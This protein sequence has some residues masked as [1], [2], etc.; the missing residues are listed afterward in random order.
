[1][2]SL[3]LQNRRYLVFKE[4]RIYN[5]T[6]SRKSVKYPFHV[7][8][9]VFCEYILFFQFNENPYCVLE[10]CHISQIRDFRR[11]EDGVDKIAIPVNYFASY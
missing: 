9:S 1:M 4:A 7:F 2:K 5:F 11:W 10:Y 8:Y 6:F 3:R